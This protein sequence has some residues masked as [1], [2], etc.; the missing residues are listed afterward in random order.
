M[1]ALDLLKT[2]DQGN[3]DVSECERNFSRLALSQELMT[4]KSFKLL[5][6]MVEV[7]GSGL[8]VMVKLQT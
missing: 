1:R 6:S 8:R 3:G 7:Q 2:V 5:S 4:M